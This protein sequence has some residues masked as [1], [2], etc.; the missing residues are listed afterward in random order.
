MRLFV[1]QTLSS[2]VQVLKQGLTNVK[3]VLNL[4]DALPQCLEPPG[5]SVLL[6]ELAEL[7]PA[8]GPIPTA[9]PLLTALSSVHAYV[10]MFTHVCRASQVFVVNSFKVKFVYRLL[11]CKIV[12][13]YS[14]VFHWILAFV[15]SK[16]FAT[17]VWASGVHHWVSKF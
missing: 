7:C 15:N 8:N 4:L 14:N 17:F 6:H 12:I 5:G 1:P 9:T 3:D 16:R 13:L 10:T 2:E 11:S